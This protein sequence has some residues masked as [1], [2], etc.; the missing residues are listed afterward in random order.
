MS[1]Q[2]APRP[3]AARALSAQEFSVQDAIGGWRGFIE[4]AIPGVVFVVCYLIWGG[5]QIP[6]IAAVGSVVVMVAARLIQRT[7]MTQA[8]SGVVGVGLGAFWAWRAGEAGEYYVPGLYITAGYCAVTVMSI[9]FRV[10]LAGVVVA[11]VRGWDRSWRRNRA[12]YRRMAWAT[13]IFAAY[14]AAKL[15]VQLPL[16]LADAV[17]ALGTAR[18]AM[19]VPLFALTLWAMWVVVRN[20][21]LPQAPADPPQ[22]T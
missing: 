5:Y 17:A 9:V 15:A 19:G 11:L 12:V 8:L 1:D 6:V 3:S 20:A 10:P 14:H 4:T 13:W 18:L 2:T 7:P 22:Q 16:Y 21:K